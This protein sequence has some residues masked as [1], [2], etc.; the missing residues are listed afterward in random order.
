MPFTFVTLLTWGTVILHREAAVV[1]RDTPATQM[2]VT[3]E[4]SD[5]TGA[6]H[7]TKGERAR[8]CYAV[9]TVLKSWSRK[10]GIPEGS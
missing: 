5:V 9:R 7:R 10:D 2:S 3:S 4:D 1:Q 6:I 8:I